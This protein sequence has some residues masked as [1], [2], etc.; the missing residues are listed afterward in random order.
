MFARIIEYLVARSRKEYSPRF[1]TIATLIGASAF[2]AG[3]PLFAFLFGI[4]FSG[5]VLASE[6]L[7]HFLALLFFLFGIPWT[8]WAVA[9][10]LWRGRGTPVPVV[11]TKEFL[12]SGPYRY[13]RNPMML[14]YFS[15]LLGWAALFNYAGSFGFALFFILVMILEI[16]FIEEKEL[17]IRFGDS[18]RQYKNQTP[19]LIPRLK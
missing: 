14:G 1:K 6:I 3:W 7:A 8:V 16:K 9:W 15:Y 5:K 4:F 18:Y 13:V 11:P 10:Q 2:L 19:F 12:P 17:E